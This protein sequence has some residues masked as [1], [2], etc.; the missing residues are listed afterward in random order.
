MIT[1]RD[2]VR[3][4]IMVVDHFGIGQR[5]SIFGGSTGQNA[6]AVKGG[7]LWTTPVL[8]TL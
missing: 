1:I 2:N 4:Q 7:E 5:F 3:A 6:G 8:R